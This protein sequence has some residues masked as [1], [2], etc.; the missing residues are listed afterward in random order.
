LI[1]N[2]FFYNWIKSNYYFLKNKIYPVKGKGNKIISKGQSFQVKYNIIG[3]NNHVY[4]EHGCYLGKCLIYIR[5]NNHKIT[6]HQG[7]VMYEGELWIED[8][9]GQI[10]I[11]EFTTI[12][13]AHLAVT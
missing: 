2:L 9:N 13:K 11:G 7:V 10:D 8:N 6:L 3:N 1:K 5:G 12:Q 4:I